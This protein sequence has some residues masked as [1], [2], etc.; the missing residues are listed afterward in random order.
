MKKT[1]YAIII[2]ATITILT[3]CSSQTA[4]SNAI[5]ENTVNN[6]KSDNTFDEAKAISIIIKDHPDF[7]TN[8]SNTITKKLPTGGKLG[9]TANVKFTTNVEKI[10]K[11]TYSVTLIKDWGITVNGKYVKSSWKYLVTPNGASLSESTD[12]DYLPNTIK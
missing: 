12:N 11:T 5:L 4:K 10:E 3:S 8:P 2:F 6:T 9:A 1:I 7:P